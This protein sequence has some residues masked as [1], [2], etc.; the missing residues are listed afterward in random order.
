MIWYLSWKTQF[1][2]EKYIILNVSWV[3]YKVCLSSKVIF[4]IKESDNTS[5][6]IYTVVKENEISLYWFI[7]KEAHDFFEILI[8]V[9]WI[10]PKTALEI[11]NLPLDDIRSA[12]ISWDTEVLKQVK[13][14]WQKAAERI[15]VELKNKIWTMIDLKISTWKSSNEND[16]MSESILALESLWY[17]RNEIIKKIRNAPKFKNAEDLVKW[18]LS[19]ALN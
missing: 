8:W 14:I 19:W 10:W 5:L 6:W 18:Y 2:W 9:N 3:W 15:V 16:I 7:E 11:L 17:S 13:W 12:I 1:I 4:E